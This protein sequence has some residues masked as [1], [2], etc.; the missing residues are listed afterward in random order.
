MDLASPSAFPKRGES[1]FKK[2]L[3]PMQLPLGNQ[4]AFKL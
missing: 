3:L 4:S 2:G 1:S